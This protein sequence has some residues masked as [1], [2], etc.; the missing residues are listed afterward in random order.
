M[1]KAKWLSEMSFV[2]LV[3]TNERLYQKHEK[4]EVPND[5]KMGNSKDGEKVTRSLLLIIQ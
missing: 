4:L 3:S 1:F 2:L 5:D